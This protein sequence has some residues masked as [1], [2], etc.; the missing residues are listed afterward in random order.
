MDPISLGLTVVGMGMQ[1]FGG[2]GQANVSKQ[3][4]QVSQDIARQEQGINQ[5]KQQQMQL[6][7]RRGLLQNFRNAQRLRSQAT[8]AAVNQGAQFGSGLQGGLAGITNTAT[9]N[10]LGINQATEIGTNIFN[11]NNAISSDKQKLASLG[12]QSAYDQ[13]L[14]NIGGM[15]AKNA[16]TISGLTKD[17]GSNFGSGIFDLVTGGGLKF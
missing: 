5:Q 14:G 10:A 9:E 7:S 1:L 4:A 11:Y 2:L 15:L 17:A 16:G 12:G 6:E 3:Q 13:S 8:A